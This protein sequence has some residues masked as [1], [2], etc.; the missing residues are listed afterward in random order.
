MTSPFG[1]RLVL[2]VDHLAQPRQL[3]VERVAALA[4][5]LLV[6][7]VRGHAVLALAVHVL[8]ADLH[9][10]GTPRR[11]D[12]RGVQALV[13]VELRHGDVVFEAT[14]HRMPERVHRAE[15][16]IAVLHRFHD[17][18]HCDEVVDL[19]E[20]L[21]LL[22][23]LLV[24]GVEVLGATHDLRLDAHLLHF[25]VQDGDDLV[26]V[27]LALGAAFRD[28]AA[29]L[30]ELVRLK[31]VERK[32]LKLPLDVVDPQPVRD[33][34]V[35][36]KRLARLE[37]A[38]VLAQRPERAHVVQ[39]VGQLD[40]DDADVLA[41][42][43]EH[44]ADGGRLLVGKALHLDARDLRHALHQLRHLRIELLGHLLGRDLRVLH[45]VVK[46][47]RYQRL[48][49]HAQVGED[50]GHLHGV[51]HERLAASATLARMR[52]AREPKR[53]RQKR[54]V[55][56]GEVRGREPLQLREAV[57]GRL[58]T[59]D[60]LLRIGC[61]RLLGHVGASQQV[62]LHGLLARG[63]LGRGSQQFFA[64]VLVARAHRLVL[65]SAQRASAG[66]MGRETRVP[67]VAESLFI[68]QSLNA[69]NI[70]RSPKPSR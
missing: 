32:I 66:R 65:L 2:P 22:R 28:H 12:D 46:K 15:G 8:G 37:D 27:M 33:G 26:E 6:A 60:V 61:E 53:L 68:A 67:K 62:V 56:F 50:D 7:P 29:D 40:D 24:D 13:H 31:V 17:H 45:G 54:L 69:W 58:G 35:D 48:H 44:L 41:H 51:H 16:R 38:A 19:R 55:R 64:I 21:A 70:S 4:A 18:A 59:R 30:L 34:C 20:A 57:L 1:V 11:T 9:L 39:P 43:D 49:V 42:G 25:G 52:L 23:H 5:F 10:E 47:R 3:L 36:L 14:G 63:G